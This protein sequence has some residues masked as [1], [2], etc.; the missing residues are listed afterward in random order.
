MEKQ[1][2]GAPKLTVIDAIAQSLAIGPVL[3]AGL[4]ATL[5]ASAAGSAAPLALLLGAIGSI[6]VGY[7][8]VFYARRFTGA[9]AIYDYVRL[10]GG[11]LLG[12]FSAGI[13]F[14]GAMFLGGAGIYLCWQ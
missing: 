13:Y 6:C 2:L 4:L 12:A 7:V 8:I 14:L 10:A 3:S 1:Q 5:V 11:R 9:G